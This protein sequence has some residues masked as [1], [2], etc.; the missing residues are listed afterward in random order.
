M[1]HIIHIH[2]TGKVEWQGVS[3]GKTTLVQIDFKLNILVLH[4]AGHSYWAN[5]VDGQ[6][7]AGAEYRLFN[8]KLLNKME[9]GEISVILENLLGFMEFPS[10]LSRATEE[11]SKKIYEHFSVP[12]YKRT[13]KKYHDFL[14]FHR[15]LPTRPSN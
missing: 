10:E 5:R 9:N 6:R 15:F 11:V 2:P 12:K 13:K 1:G 4:I 7:Y 8:F 14:D 3:T